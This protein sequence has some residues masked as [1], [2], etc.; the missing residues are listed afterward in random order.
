M[1]DFEDSP[2]PAKRLK[3]AEIEKTPT[4]PTRAFRAVKDAVFGSRTEGHVN[5][6]DYYDNE[7]GNDKSAGLQATPPKQDGGSI[8][9]KPLSTLE[10]WKLAR[11][12]HGARGTKTATESPVTNGET[13]SQTPTPTPTKRRKR[14]SQLELGA[15]G[16]RHSE[17]R[18]GVEEPSRE[19]GGLAEG[20][21]EAEDTDDGVDPLQ[22]DV[23]EVIPQRAKAGKILESPTSKSAMQKL[24][25]SPRPTTNS[26]NPRP[27]PYSAPPLPVTPSARKRGRP[28]GSGKKAL[29]GR[30]DEESDL[31][32]KVIPAKGVTD[33]KTQER[34]DFGVSGEEQ[35]P[36]DLEIPSSDVQISFEDAFTTFQEVISQ[37]SLE[38]LTAF[39]TSLL[40]QLTLRQ[41]LPIQQRLASEYE[42]VHSL[43]SQTVLAGEGNS[44]LV[45]GSRGSGKSTLVETV[46]SDL[47]R[48]HKDDFHVIRL[49]GFIHTDDKLTLREI[50]R[51]LGREMEV[52]DENTGR[53]NYADALTSLLALLAHTPDSIDPDAEQSTDMTTKA[54]TFILD[55]FDL[56]ASHPRQ[57]LLYNLF[58]V[59]QSRN[60]PI[61]VLGLTTKISAVESLEKRVKSRFGQRY[62]H[63]SLPRSF[64]TF[65]ETCKSVLV[66]PKPDSTKLRLPST[67]DE[68]TKCLHQAWS[69]YLN[70]L[71]AHPS[72]L[73]YLRSI[74]VSTSS[75]PQFIASCLIPIGMLPTV[76]TPD[77][78]ISN[79]L[80]PP[81]SKLHLLPS[82]S[83]LALSLLI[84]A[85][86]LDI[87]LSTDLCNFEMVYE[88]YVNL[89][90][91]LRQQTSA[92][93]QLALGQGGRVWGQ[94][95]AKREWE[96]LA[97]LTLVLL[98]VGT[99]GGGR[100]A[101][102]RGG[103]WRV[104]VGLEEIAG[105]VSGISSVMGRWCKEI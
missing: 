72:F 23:V 58:D 5:G 65:S 102:G 39:K 44:M 87:I 32:F 84:A 22:E 14:K 63:L 35:Q 15:N 9:T 73:T 33:Q 20:D 41:R 61:A 81:D 11:Q 8:W 21:H 92:S 28:P 75:L 26:A 2:R 38:A 37:I 78:F 94:A 10:R 50:W 83:D 101:G 103:M 99:E 27:P 104:D 62:V 93:G 70:H 45:I 3:V 97:E 76:P 31:S 54:V 6:A 17:K 1:D 71:F 66:P 86:R 100:K 24:P 13:T 69:T 96:R 43:L 77:S 56:F 42:K 40:S 46:I 74:H 52:E 18:N 7:N 68:E 80:A 60:A 105:S 89:A 51:Q 55:E 59:A 88:E 36:P 64:S 30:R 57:T 67:D 85:A 98:V 47:A 48:D 34:L 25:G 82:L 91:R 49:N 53:N 19:G 4:L 16:E 12:Q 90:S 79:S 29:I 95:V